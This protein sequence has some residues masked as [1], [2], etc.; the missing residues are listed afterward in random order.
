M[1][2]RA[3]ALLEKL[4]SRKRMEPS[5]LDLS[6]VKNILVVRQHDQLGDFLLSTPVLR[7][8]K[9]RFPGCRLGL[10]V[11]GYFADTMLHHPDVDELLVWK[12]AGGW[13]FRNALDYA[14][15]LRSGW[16]VAVVL[17]TVSHSFTSDAV[18]ALSGAKVIVGSTDRPFPGTQRNF[19][20]NVEVA[21][22]P[23]PRPQ[24]QRN[25]DLVRVLGADTDALAPSMTLTEEEK[26]AA[27]AALLSQGWDPERPTVGLHIGAGKAA[28]RWPAERFA[29]VAR[30]LDARGVQ[31]LVAWG[32]Q[33]TGLYA[34]FSSAYPGRRFTVGAPPLRLLAA[35]FS[36]MDAMLVND[37]GMLHLAAACGIPLVAV[38]G[39]TP[40]EE[41][42]PLGGSSIP[43]R[44]AG[45]SVDA[46]SV[47]DVWGE[48]LK[49]LPA[50]PRS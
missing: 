46:V 47:E 48:L 2:H 36:W 20:Y 17:N 45:A 22:A 9:T 6:G 15:K 21:P 30:R 14:R 43:L 40:P 29:E 34:S 35:H 49:I 24:T 37:T 13:T 50:G 16:D 44:G 19:L 32:P 3:Y 7:A 28:N 41:W 10:C 39:P 12:P 23:F 42:C 26:G 1:K 5:S 38:F 31:V 4:L 11:R 33:E 8:L 27:H 25:L 18:A